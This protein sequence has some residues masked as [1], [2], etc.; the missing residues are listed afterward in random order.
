MIYLLGTSPHNEDFILTYATNDKGI[1]EIAR[2]YFREIFPGEL[3]VTVT[4]DHTI[5]EVFVLNDKYQYTMTFYI[6]ELTPTKTL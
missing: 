1:E 3:D 4:I 6:S 2:K 5:N